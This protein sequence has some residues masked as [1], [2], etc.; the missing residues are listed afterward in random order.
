MASDTDFSVTFWGVRG[1]IACPGPATARYGGNTPCI[2]IRCG[3]RILIFDAGTGIRELGESLEARGIKEAELFFSHT[4]IDHISG[5]PFFAFCYDEANRLRIWSGDLDGADSIEHALEKFMSPP[6][7]PLGLDFLMAQITYGHFHVGD[8]VDLGEGVHIR[9]GSLNHPNGCTGYR[10]EYGGKSICFAT[11]TEHTETGPDDAL[12]D[13][14]R[15]ADILIYDATYTDAEYVNH[16]GWGHST[17]EE[18]VRLC[19]AAGVKQL[20]LFH[21]LPERDDDALDAIGEAAKARFPGAVVAREGSTL[22]P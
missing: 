9:T 1:S 17:W 18:G 5:F 7:F 14:I 16:I 4:H 22:V 13:F 6:L 21:H 15:G 19:E 3:E 10:I 2:E 20:A 8:T 11:D 12:L